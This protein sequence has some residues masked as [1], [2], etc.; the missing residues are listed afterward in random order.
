MPF[1]RGFCGRFVGKSA[2]STHLFALKNVV[3]SN[4]S[5]EKVCVSL[6][7]SQVVVGIATANYWLSAA[8]NS[9]PVPLSHSVT[10]PLKQGSNPGAAGGGV[11]TGEQ[12]TC[13]TG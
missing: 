5:L 10:A 4:Y 11:F 6:N 3:M 9:S 13:R 7:Y 12:F 2:L 1:F 8:S